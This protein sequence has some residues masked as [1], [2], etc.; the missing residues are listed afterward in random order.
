MWLERGDR[1]DD[2]V[3]GVRRMLNTARS[4]TT[5]DTRQAEVERAHPPTGRFVS[6]GGVGLHYDDRGSG[7]PLVYLHGAGAMAAELHAGPLGNLLAKRYRVVAIDRPGHGFSGYA[8]HLAGPRAQARLLRQALG[9]LG[10]ERPV[11]VG[12]SWGGAMALAYAV[13]YPGELAGIVNIA[14]WCY[15]ARQTS[16][17][18]MASCALPLIEATSAAPFA[19]GLMSHFGRRTVERIFAPAPVPPEFA[20]FPLA[21]SLRIGQLRANGRDLLALNPDVLRLQRHYRRLDLPVE[22]MV[23]TADRIVDPQRHGRRLAAKVP[24]ARLTE[25]QGAGHMP[26]HAAPAAVVLAVERLLAA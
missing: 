7:H 18:L 8:P 26:H 19:P 14:G 24:G 21:M 23:G 13:E 15:A 4:V 1:H 22:I 16:I 3:F 12:H 10:I 6:V 20:D 11:L 9:R 5:G 25:I 2:R 17:R